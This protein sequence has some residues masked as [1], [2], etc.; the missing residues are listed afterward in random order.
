MKKIRMY[1]GIPTVG[2]VCDAQTYALRDLEERYGDKIEFVY[3]KLC[4]RRIFHDYA[5]N[6]IVEEFLDSECDVLWFLDSDISPPNHVLDLISMHWDK[7]QV[8]A[9]PYPVF[10]KPGSSENLAVVFTVYKQ[11]G[12]GGMSPSNIPYEGTEFVD[13]AAT[14]CLFIKREVFSKLKKPY[15]EFKYEAESRFLTEGEDLGFCRK[16]HELGIKTFV[17]YSMVCK[18][19]KTVCLLEVNNYATEYANKSVLNYDR[20]IKPQIEELARRLT[21]KKQSVPRSEAPKSGLILPPGLLKD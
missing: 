3:P 20:M 15:F 12:Q 7:W 5:R 16:L 8:A 14:G 2:N 17:D 4:V 21:A 18:H 11:I 19:Y 13:G 10:M 9:A 1:V 6:S